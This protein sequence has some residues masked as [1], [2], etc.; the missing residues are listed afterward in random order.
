MGVYWGEVL[1]FL[2]LKVEPDL[3]REEFHP[4][5]RIHEDEEEQE[6]DYEE[7][8]EEDDEEEEEYGDKEEEKR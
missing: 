4:H 7:G 1:D 5:N 3:V 8:E 6:D 2:V